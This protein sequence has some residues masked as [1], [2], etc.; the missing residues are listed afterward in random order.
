MSNELI[1][2]GF[3]AN[4]LQ[5]L[6]SHRS[7]GGDAVGAVEAFCRQVSENKDRQLSK[8]DESDLLRREIADIADAAIGWA[9]REGLTVPVLA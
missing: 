1:T 9:R 8:L 4:I 5:A 7:P 3:K 6:L 2:E